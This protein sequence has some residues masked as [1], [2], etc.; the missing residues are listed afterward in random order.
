MDSK[1][2]ELSI[3]EMEKGSGGSNKKSS[4]SV[5]A[6]ATRKFFAETGKAVYTLGKAAAQW[7]SNL[8]SGD[9]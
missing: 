1:K 9:K 3:N 4:G 7:F 8:F 2:K 5:S 6:E